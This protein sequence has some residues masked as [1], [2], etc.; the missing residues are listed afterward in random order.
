MRWLLILLTLACVTTGCAEDLERH[1]AQPGEPFVEQLGSFTNDKVSIVGVSPNGE[2]AL[3][4]IRENDDF[5]NPP[6]LGIATFGSSQDPTLLDP[7]ISHAIFSNSGDQL[8]QQSSDGTLI[9]S[10]PDASNPLPLTTNSPGTLAFTANDSII[11][12]LS[13]VDEEHRQLVMIDVG[14]G[15]KRTVGEPFDRASPI[16]EF[17]VLFATNPDAT[18]ALVNVDGTPHLMDLLTGERTV[19][20]AGDGSVGSAAFSPDGQSL[21]FVSTIKNEADGYFARGRSALFVLR[22]DEEVDSQRITQLTDRTE[23]HLVSQ[24]LW[25]KDSTELLVSRFEDFFISD[26]R[27]IDVET[28]RAEEVDPAD[29]LLPGQSP[30]LF[31]R[32]GMWSTDGAIIGLIGFDLSEPSSGTRVMAL[33]RAS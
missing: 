17:D 14:S 21:A 4:E 5:A 19:L 33:T 6:I 18:Q 8:L 9:L 31:V 15:E 12:V 13:D 30:G 24:P 25:S 32:S 10:D 16:V 22:L 28:G 26:L 2:H 7:S 3:V 23:S 29:M 1:N 11:T 20:L 27:V